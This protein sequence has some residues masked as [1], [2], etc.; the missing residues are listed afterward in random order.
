[1]RVIVGRENIEANSLPAAFCEAA[2]AFL[3][4]GRERHGRLLVC[5]GK[6]DFD[7]VKRPTSML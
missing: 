4:L 2:I 7:T 6:A 3:L 1:M 5:S